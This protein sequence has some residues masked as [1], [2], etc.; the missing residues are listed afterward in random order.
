MLV[1]FFPSFLKGPF[2]QRVFFFSPLYLVLGKCLPRVSATVG[3]KLLPAP[4]S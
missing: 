3:D 2:H 1:L 4:D